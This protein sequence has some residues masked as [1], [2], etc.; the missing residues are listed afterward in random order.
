[1]AEK[2]C[3]LVKSGG[4]MMLPDYQNGTDVVNTATKAVM[5]YTP[6][7][8]GYLCCISDANSFSKVDV[9]EDNVM[10]I[11]IANTGTL[12]VRKGHTYKSSAAIR[13]AKFYPFK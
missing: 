8:N 5:N 6:T 11:T 10:I 3:E 4:G 7:E 2:V 1:M 12:I 13:L 9:Y